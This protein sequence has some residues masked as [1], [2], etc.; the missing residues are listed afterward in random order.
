MGERGVIRN[1]EAKQQIADFSGLRYG[2]ITPTDLDAFLDF[3]NRL[4]VFVEC[5]YMN[6][7]LSYGQRLALERLVDA[8][9]KPPERYA[10]GFVVAHSGGGDIDFA[11]TTVR[12]FRWDGKWLAPRIDGASLREGV[13]AFRARYLT[14]NVVQFP[15]GGVRA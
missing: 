2:K 11:G 3:G 10:V 14:S 1:R 13:D 9:H 15:K 12:Q 7:P 8:C 4:F 5:K 6:A